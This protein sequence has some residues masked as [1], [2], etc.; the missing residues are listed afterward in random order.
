MDGFMLSVIFSKTLI[1]FV[2]KKA[3][4]NHIVDLIEAFLSAS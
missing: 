2:E 4:K 3:G 1:R